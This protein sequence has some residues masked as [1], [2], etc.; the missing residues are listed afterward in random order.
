MRD[1]MELVCA[2]KNPD[3]LAEIA[4]MLEGVVELLPRPDS[5]GEISETA[6]SFVGNARIKAHLIAKSTGLPALGDDSG[7]EVDALDGAPGVNSADFGGPQRCYSDNCRY[8][9]AQMEGQTDRRA[10][11]RTVL[12]VAWPDGREVIAEGVCEGN[13]ACLES[14]ENGFGY[15]SVF[16]PEVPPGILKNQATLRTFAQMTMAEKNLVSPR[17]VALEGLLQKLKTAR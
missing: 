4:A 2:T 5:V 15:D 7:L 17:S 16:I 13:I 1:V 10:R 11:L 12:V 3:K 8:L 6:D 9:L 14:G